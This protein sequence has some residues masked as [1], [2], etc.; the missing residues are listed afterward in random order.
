M[1]RGGSDLR[2]RK[3]IYIA[4]SVMLWVSPAKGAE[5]RTVAE[6]SARWAAYY[7]SVYHVP[8][9]LVEAI[10]D[11]ESGWNPY[12]VSD[13]GAVGLMQLMP[14]TANRFGLRNRFVIEENI[15]G[16][17]AYLDWLMRLFHGDLRLVVA[18]YYAGEQRIL[19]R[20][21][22]YSSTDTYEYVR[23][24]AAIYRARRLAESNNKEA[25]RE[26]AAE[27]ERPPT[28]PWPPS[29]PRRKIQ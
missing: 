22:A 7:A 18:G 10:I 9:E 12:A 20:G 24:V 11:V 26:T 21:L 25:K 1:G 15:R 23:R 19:P 6:V 4:V 13:K 28:A 27:Q 8:V 3:A 14:E 2:H 16:G 17:V 29:L 5:G